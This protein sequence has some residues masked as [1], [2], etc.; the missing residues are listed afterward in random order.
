[1]AATLPL[2]IILIDF[3][4]GIDFKRP[5]RY[6]GYVLVVSLYAYIR[7][8]FFYNA[9]EF[10]DVEANALTERLFHVPAL[11]GQYLRLLLL[12]VNLSI[13]YQQINFGWIFVLGLITILLGIRIF[14]T[15]TKKAN[16]S[17]FGLLWILITLIP[18]YNM[19][20]I[21]NAFAERYLYLPLPGFFIVFI[22]SINSQSWKCKTLIVSLL[23]LCF[24]FL[25]INR[26]YLWKDDYS[27]WGD[28]IKKV[29]THRA[30]F[31]FGKASS[32]RGRLDDAVSAYLKAL[33]IE[34]YDSDTYVNL[35]IAYFEQ[36]NVDLAIANFKK[37]I[38][39]K[40]DDATTHYLLGR[41][42]IRKGLIEEAKL[43]YREALN[44]DPGFTPAM[45]ALR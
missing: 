31:K 13:E 22:S 15:A 45:D 14:I 35:G 3:Y 11:L 6:I 44:I 19:I 28:A 38:W 27:L 34:P 43:E 17:A 29:S 10:Q 21:D 37:S 1:M 42:Y 16:I 18:V 8:Y 20:P 7:F 36:G 24:V 33:S 41:S 40:N 4:K 30:Y 23:L 12:P 39:M 32:E 5:W 2:T 26:N 9:I 25:T